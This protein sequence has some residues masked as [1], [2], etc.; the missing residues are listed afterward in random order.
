MVPGAAR[1]LLKSGIES[2]HL[3]LEMTGWLCWFDI[4]PQTGLV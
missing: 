1:C 4:Q 2:N 3:K